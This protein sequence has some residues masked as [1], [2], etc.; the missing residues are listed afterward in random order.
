MHETNDETL[1]KEIGT[2]LL[3]FSE[4]DLVLNWS[5]LELVRNKPKAS[6]SVALSQITRMQL[7]NEREIS[8]SGNNEKELLRI[9]AFTKEEANSWFNNLQTCLVV[10]KEDIQDNLKRQQG[11]MYR[12]QRLLELESRKREREKQKRELDRKLGAKGYIRS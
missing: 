5:A 12:E 11:I 6:G 7:V 10:F 3:K 4:V 8:I 1:S 2:I 9:K